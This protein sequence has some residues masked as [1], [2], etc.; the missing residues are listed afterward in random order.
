MPRPSRNSWWEW[1]ERFS[2]SLVPFA[3]AF[4]VEARGAQ[5]TGPAFSVQNGHPVPEG[6]V[7]QHPHDHVLLLP[8]PADLLSQLRQPALQDYPGAALGR[9][10]DLGNGSKGKSPENL[11]LLS[12]NQVKIFLR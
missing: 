6:F 3:H 11:Q 7:L 10:Q 4:L 2:N 1:G 8:D 9:P 12:G 5:D